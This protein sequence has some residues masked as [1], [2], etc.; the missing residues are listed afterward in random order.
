V[1]TTD[2]RTMLLVRSSA[3]FLW[4]AR[5]PE[6]VI[7]VNTPLRRRTESAGTPRGGARRSGGGS[8]ANPSG[9]SWRT[10][11]IAPTGDRLYVLDQNGLHAW[12]LET[13]TEESVIQA[14]DLN[15]TPLEGESNF[16]GMALSP[17]GKVLALADRN[18]TVVLMDTARQR[19]V[20]QI[21]P[22]SGE[23]PG[24]WR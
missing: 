21:P 14:R 15:W 16:N 3:M 8:N 5:T 20:G 23:T 24:P 19:V 18:G 2:G 22:E 4:Q 6:R 12:G 17:D 1:K 11:Q 13:V 10:V 7:R 9:F